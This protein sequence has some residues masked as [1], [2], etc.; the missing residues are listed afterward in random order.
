MTGFGGIREETRS[1]DAGTGSGGHT[2]C[3]LSG[4]S[5]GVNE[6]AGLEVRPGVAPAFQPGRY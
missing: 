6:H 1:I 5:D 4:T 3:G 2:I